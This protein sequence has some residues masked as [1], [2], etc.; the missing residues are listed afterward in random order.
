VFVGAAGA[1]HFNGGADQDNLD[2]S[3]SDA[4]VTVNL[5]TNVLSG[6]D[7]ANDHI[8]GG[9]DGAIGSDYNDTLIGFDH[10]GTSAPDVF[11]NEFFGGKGNDYIEGKNGDDYIEGGDDD[12]VIY[13]GGGADEV[14][15]GNGGNGADY[16][17]GGAGN[18]VIYGGGGTSG[19]TTTV[20]ESFEWN[21]QPDFGN[22]A[23]ANGFTQDTGN[24]NVTF[25][26][27]NE[28]GTAVS[29]YENSVQNI[30]PKFDSY[31]SIFG[32]WLCPVRIKSMG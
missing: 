25:S 16:V 8:I 26:V 14:Y 21:K 4:A 3:N 12:D 28:T 20:R 17:E 15:G 31:G 5:T 22:N 19:G 1:D 29:E 32:V 2:Y 30:A 9:I 7:A 27:L 13:A 23:D 24:V 18:D 10:E 6:G 11:T